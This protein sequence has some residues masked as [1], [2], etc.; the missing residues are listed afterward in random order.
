MFLSHTTSHVVF[1]G[2]H[3]S[4]VKHTRLVVISTLFP[5]N[6]F[7]EHVKRCVFNDCFFFL[8]MSSVSSGHYTAYAYSPSAGWFLYAHSVCYCNACT[9]VM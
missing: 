1:Q 9:S 4:R 3:P 2:S 5:H 8:L 7:C 6:D